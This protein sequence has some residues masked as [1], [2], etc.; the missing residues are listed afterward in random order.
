MQAEREGGR[1][2]ENREKNGRWNET[3]ERAPEHGLNGP[4]KA[5]LGSRSNSGGN[6]VHS[7]TNRMEWLHH[8]H[9]KSK[10]SEGTADCTPP[11]PPRQ[12]VPMGPFVE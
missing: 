11:P 5:R 4:A 7:D 8:Q 10:G 3:S 2:G 12:L 1:E 6:G 9:P